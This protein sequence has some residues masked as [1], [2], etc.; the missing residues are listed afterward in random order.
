MRAGRPLL[1]DH[2]FASTCELTQGI[3]RT[4]KLHPDRAA[5]RCQGREQTWAQFEDRVARLASALGALGVAAGD[6]TAILGFNSDRYIEFLYATLWAGGIAVPLNTRWAFAEL[7]DCID[8][9]EPRVLFAD[10]EHAATAL[11][12]SEA[13]PS[14]VDVIVAGGDFAGGAISY[15]ELVRHHRPVA[16]ARRGDDDVACL[17]YTGGTTGR[18]KGVMLTHANLMANSLVALANMNI[19][20]QTVHLHVSPLFHVAGGA[21]LFSVTLAG[22]THVAVPRF[23][24]TSFLQT[25]ADERITVT[26][27]VP[28]MLNQLLHQLESDP[29]L[30]NLDLSRLELLTYGGAP[31]PAALLRRAIKALPHVRFM[32]GYGMTECSPIISTLGPRFHCLEGPNAQYL[33][34]AGRPVVTA[35]VAI[36]DDHGNELPIGGVGEVCVRGPMVMQGYWRLPELT[37]ETL[38]GGWMHTGDAGYLDEAGF[39][40]L[41]DRVK[42][43]IV[44]GGENVYSAEVEAALH[45]H[46]NVLECAVIGVPD[47]A[48]GEAVHAI[49]VPKQGTTLTERELDDACRQ[50]IAGY[51]CPKAYTIRAGILPRT[52]AGKV[53]K[54]ELRA[55][56]WTG[57]ERRIN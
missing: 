46:P 13:C 4:A 40:F 24:P 36:L 51:K 1:K 19:T 8:D 12:L 14:I 42:D 39:L 6:R 37:A 34:S 7:R 45:Q 55:P 48:W 17:F 47:A 31:M 44:S 15:E 25:L 3:R 26:I 54:A 2:G 20:E 49:V 52:A 29:R 21:R 5:L 11:R 28:A 33:H 27:I 30:A 10:A 35:E 16:D 18:S 41:V 9:A 53:L 57:H 56:F 50:R 32:Q 22:G 43:M 23:D 38:R